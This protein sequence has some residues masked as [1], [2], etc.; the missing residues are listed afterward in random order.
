ML[1]Q[2]LEGHDKVPIIFDDNA[3]VWDQASDN[4]APIK[5]QY[6]WIRIRLSEAWSQTRAADQYW[7]DDLLLEKGLYAKRVWGAH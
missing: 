2:D 5:Q 7:V 4:F 1:M 6:G 3:R